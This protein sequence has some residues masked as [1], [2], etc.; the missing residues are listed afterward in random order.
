MILDN[1]QLLLFDVDGT[2]A[3]RDEAALLPEAAD[4]FRALAELLASGRPIPN[5]ALVTNQGGPAVRSWMEEGGF[6]QP[7]RYPTLEQVQTRLHGL[8]AQIPLDVQLYVAYAYQSS[9]GNWAPVPVRYAGDPAWSRGW[10]K[11]N[12]GMIDQAIADSHVDGR[13]VMMV[14][15]TDTDE[16][17]AAAAGIIFMYVGNFWEL[18]EHDLTPVVE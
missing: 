15:D 5:I 17:A 9:K 14:G 3:A 6:G 11:P 18:V 4:F 10:R 12:P 1:I 7:A 16:Q 13:A 8:V 2:I